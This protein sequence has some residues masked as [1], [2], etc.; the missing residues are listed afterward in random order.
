M[1]SQYDRHG[2]HRMRA[3]ARRLQDL[4]NRAAHGGVKHKG[5]VHYSLTPELQDNQDSHLLTS[6]FLSFAL[7]LSHGCNFCNLLRLVDNCITLVTE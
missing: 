4:T 5:V 1:D 6:S 3:L 7:H 2:I